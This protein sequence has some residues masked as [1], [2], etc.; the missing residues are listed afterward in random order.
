MYSNK[1]KPILIIH[2]KKYI[3]L[4]LLYTCTNSSRLSTNLIFSF[5]YIKLKFDHVNELLWNLTS[6]KRLIATVWN[7]PMPHSHQRKFPKVL[8][9]KWLTYI[10]M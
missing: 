6:D 10:L 5:R 9:N 4:K 8:N 2:F 1:N 7:S 3:F